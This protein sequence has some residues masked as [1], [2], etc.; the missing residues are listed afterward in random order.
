MVRMVEPGTDRSPA[1]NDD[2]SPAFE[3]GGHA[4]GEGANDT[5][6]EAMGFMDELAS[7]DSV[8]VWGHDALPA[9]DEPVIRGMQEWIGLAGAIHSYDLGESPWQKSQ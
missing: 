9:D 3:Q 6:V 8:T 1:A 2:A 4:D 5:E 7:F